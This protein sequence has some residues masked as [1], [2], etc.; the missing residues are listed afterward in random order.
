MAQ[1]GQ[2]IAAR[3]NFSPPSSPL[4]NPGEPLV[5]YSKPPTIKLPQ[6]GQKPLDHLSALTE[7][8]TSE[9]PKLDN[10]PLVDR[11]VLPSAPASNSL[12]DHSEPQMGSAIAEGLN[13]K[14]LAR[15]LGRSDVAVINARRERDAVGFAEWSRKRDPQSLAWEYRGGRYYPIE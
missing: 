3:P 11:S 1:L 6:Q 8:V 9:P 7:S 10:S 5:V 13:Q 14:A 2:E 12:V 15:R 4:Y